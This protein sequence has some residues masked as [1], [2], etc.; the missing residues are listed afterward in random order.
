MEDPDNRGR[1]HNIRVRGVPEVIEPA[2]IPQAIC[3][4]FNDLLGRSAD[5]PFKMQR[6]HRALRPPPRDSGPLRD[7]IC[8]I[9][10]FPL[11]EEILRK[12]RDRGCI[13]YNDTELKLFQDLSQITLQ[14]RHALRPLLE[15]LHSHNIQYRWKFPF[16]LAASTGVALHCCTHRKIYRPT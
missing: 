7:V 13:M 15:A 3:S 16:G 14:N 10:N 12:A 2:A 8:C 9:V 5:S 11:K 4:I 1:R 6:A